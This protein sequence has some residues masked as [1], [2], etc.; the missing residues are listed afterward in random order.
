SMACATSVMGIETSFKKSVLFTLQ[1]FAVSTLTRQVLNWRYPKEREY[2]SEY[3]ASNSVNS[4][5]FDSLGYSIGKNIYL[6]VLQIVAAV[7]SVYFFSR[8]ISKWDLNP[9]VTMIFTAVTSALYF[10]TQSLFTQLEWKYDRVHYQ[11]DDRNGFSYVGRSMILLSLIKGSADWL[12]LDLPLGKSFI[13][14]ACIAGT[15]IAL[16]D[17][18]YQFNASKEWPSDM[19]GT[20]KNIKEGIVT[21]IHE[22]FSFSSNNPPIKKKKTQH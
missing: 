18:S 11:E 16:I 21:I 7:G 6:N 8:A 12:K 14:T 13:K 1:A 17:K 3:P 20:W 2:P 19:D 10:A 9:R 22:R 4:F 15:L 5:S